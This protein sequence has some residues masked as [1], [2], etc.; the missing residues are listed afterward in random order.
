MPLCVSEIQV[1]PLKEGVDD[2]QLEACLL[3]LCRLPD[4]DKGDRLRTASIQ[5]G[6]Q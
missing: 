5:G 3:T 6:G 1:T 2:L 4:A